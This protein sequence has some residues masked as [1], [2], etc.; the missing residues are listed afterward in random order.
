MADP[1]V[2]TNGF[3]GLTTATGGTVYTHLVDTEEVTLPISREE[4]DAA[5]MGDGAK[6]MYPGRLNSDI[7]V[8][9]R[10]SF[11]ATSADSLL[12]PYFNNKTAVRC[13][14]RAV[15]AA[16]STSNPSY[17][18]D[19]VYVVNGPG[20]AGGHGAILKNTYKLVLAPGCIITRST[21]T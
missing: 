11:S 19:R 15:N 4:L 6:T 3:L 14:A 7:T 8:R 1:V 2:F 10:Q 21:S 20:I 9:C 13:K 5:V 18:F 16:V 12:W 17:K